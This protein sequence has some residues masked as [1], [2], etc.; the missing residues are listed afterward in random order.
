MAQDEPSKTGGRALAEVTP[1]RLLLWLP[2]AA[3]AG[4]ALYFTAEREPA[5]W[6]AC[7]LCAGLIA[8]AIVARRRPFGFPIALALAALSAG[9]CIATLQTQRIAHPIL[10]AATWSA[11][12]GGF[13]EAREEHEKSDRIVVR[14][15]RFE[16]PRITEKPTCVRVSVRKSTAPEVGAFVTPLAA[17]FALWGGKEAIGLLHASLVAGL[18]TTP[19]AAYHFH[20]IAP[21]GVLANL[22]AMPAVPVMVMPMGILGALTMP[23]SYDAIF[24]QLMGAGIDW[25]IVVVLW[26]TSLPGSV[27]HMPAFGTGPLLVATFGLLLMR[28]PR[29]PLR[30]SGAVLV[31]AAT[32]W[33]L[34]LLHRMCWWAATDNRRRC[35]V[36]A[37][38]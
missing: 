23:F 8:I 27:G 37:A 1:G 21:Y 24:W 11:Q 19:Y 14:V 35:A 30:W 25:M 28:L 29:T 17:R 20:R 38:S 31:A 7:G 5:W 13:V 34:S 12:V 26:V 15:H 10:Q 18:A 9:I 2:V 3:G 22:L 32:V 36:P 16:A 4:I 33:A 6:A